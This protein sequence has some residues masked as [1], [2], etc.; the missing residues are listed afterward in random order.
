MIEFSANQILDAQKKRQ[1][2]RN[3]FFPLPQFFHV[4]IVHYNTFT[5]V[6]FKVDCAHACLSAQM[7]ARLFPCYAM[8]ALLLRSVMFNLLNAGLI[9]L[10]QIEIQYDLDITSSDITHI[11]HR[12]KTCVCNGR[13]YSFYLYNYKS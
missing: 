1:L 2:K 5:K 9:V 4:Q 13:G 10:R 12:S 7:S 3:H 8:I 11:Q 6:S